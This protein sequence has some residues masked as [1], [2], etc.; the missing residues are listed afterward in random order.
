MTHNTNIL[1][2]LFSNQV[3]LKLTNTISRQKETFIPINKNKVTIYCCGVTVYDLC[4]LGHARSY[5]VWDVLRRYL[6]WQGYE[7]TYVQNFTDIDDKIIERA[8][9]ESC[10]MEEVS[11]KNIVAFHEDMN[12]LNILPSDKM[13]R[14]T[15]CLDSIREMI[16][17][18]VEND[19]A[20]A[21]DGNVYF[22]VKSSKNYGKLSRRNLDQQ[23]LNAEGRITKDQTSK[24]KN[25]FDFALWKKSKKDEPSFSSPWGEGR[26]GWHIECSAM[27]KKEL[28]ETI[29]IHLG[30]GDLIFPHHEN[31][32]AQSEAVNNKELANYWL[33]NGM[34]NVG[35]KKMSKSLGN[36]TTI[37]SL[38]NSG[39]SP[40]TLR[41]FILQAHYRKP[42]DFTKEAIDAA[43][44]GWKKINDALNLGITYN[45]SKSSELNF[46][47]TNIEKDSK[48]FKY[49]EEL[50]G[51]R[52]DFI[53]A[54]NDDLN[55][56]SGLSIIFQLAKSIRALANK[57][58]ANSI[59]KLTKHEKQ[60]LKH[61]WALLD[62]LTESLGFKAEKIDVSSLSVD[63]EKILT[64]IN[65]RKLAKKNHDFHQADK[66]RD[67]LGT[68]G[69]ELID[70]P[71]GETDWI[72]K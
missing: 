53:F 27:V 66:I 52:T 12:K 5:I 46:E 3:P 6:I 26:P 23:Q 32:I 37:R 55:T 35:G 72:K 11:N 18:L 45:F 58:E 60:Q 4:H 61:Q 15:K 10:S 34:V 68:M 29:D 69:I 47:P 62:E 63:K 57:T 44:S 9:K 56:S 1:K 65:K 64:Y 24:K 40:M 25:V 2:S 42:I 43:A 16:E 38:L 22:D 30:G 14:A 48:K 7:V 50:S 19:H 49:S 13:P 20:Y 71:G 8:A 17:E 70:K 39:V 21:I 36:F 54:L 28:G 67:L 31:E 41:L 51:L 33:H 59:E